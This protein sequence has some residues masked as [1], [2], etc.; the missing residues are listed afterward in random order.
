MALDPS[1]S[2]QAK[3]PQVDYANAIANAQQLY[4][5]ELAVKKAQR[6]QQQQNALRDLFAKSRSS[7]TPEF[8][9][10]V[11]AIG[12]P[13]VGLQYEQGVAN[14]QKN[15]YA[16]QAE[17]VK[18]LRPYA[19][20]AAANPTWDNIRYNLGRAVDD[21][22]M[23]VN[24]AAQ[25]MGQLRSQPQSEWANVIRNTYSSLDEQIRANAPLTQY[26][27]VTTN[28]QQQQQEQTAAREEQRLAMEERR[29]QLAEQEA[30]RKTQ[31][32]STPIAT[33]ER[34]RRE[35]AHPKATLALRTY[36]QDVDSQIRDLKSLRNSR[37]L[38]AI[39]GVVGSRTP[40][41]TPEARKA[42]ALWNK[43]SAKGM[44]TSLQNIRN[45]SPTG[46][47]LGN[48]SDAEG[49][50]LRDAYGTLDLGQDAKDIRAAIDQ[51]IAT[52]E[53]GKEN[54]RAAYDMTYEYRSG[55]AAAPASP[56]PAT[57]TAGAKVIDFSK[58]RRK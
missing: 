19:A 41:L 21:G 18:A 54:M 43:I 4:T 34:Q 22:V 44:F 20:A 29:V 8:I 14:L 52:H 12:G 38:D 33:K 46:G 36:E 1:I 2:L 15:R 16:A 10:Q 40:D 51:I 6:E 45:A 37:G 53:A 50:A 17:K 30:Q 49:R 42:R 24:V 28:L 39:S 27:Q 55:G 7:E 58:L 48:Q 13:D 47:A 23:D 31:E 3:T 5:N 11:Y 35:A 56:A 25:F 32:T 26:Q 9:R 57:S